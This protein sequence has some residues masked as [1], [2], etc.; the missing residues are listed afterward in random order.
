VEALRAAVDY[1]PQTP[2]AD[3]LARFVN[4]FRSAENPLR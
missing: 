1:A 3:G 4:W 2:I